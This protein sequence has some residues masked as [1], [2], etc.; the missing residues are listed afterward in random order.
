[1]GHV[2]VNFL[3]SSL[4]Q[5]VTD[6]ATENQRTVHAAVKK[7]AQDE[8]SLFLLAALRQ[9]LRLASYLCLVRQLLLGCVLSPV[10]PVLTAVVMALPQLWCFVFPGGFVS[11]FIKH[12][13]SFTVIASWSVSSSGSYSDSHCLKS[14]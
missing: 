2:P 6:S 13:C 1:M 12:S 10:V 8:G 3:E 7:L 4:R 14:T 9:Q 11:G 5:L